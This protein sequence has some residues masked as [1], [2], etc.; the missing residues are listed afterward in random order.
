MSC[1]RCLSCH[2]LASICS[3]VRCWQAWPQPTR[4]WE[5]WTS[6]AAATQRAWSCA[7]TRQQTVRTSGCNH[8]VQHDRHLH[9]AVAGAHLSHAQANSRLQTAYLTASLGTSMQQKFRLLTAQGLCKC[10]DTDTTCL[11][12]CCCRRCLAEWSIYFHLHLAES[13]AAKGQAEEAS[14]QVEQAAA[15]AGSQG[16]LQQQVRGHGLRTC[17]TCLQNWQQ[18]YALALIE[19]RHQPPL[20]LRCNVHHV[21]WFP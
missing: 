18:P 11:L 1:R 20:T 19:G 21:L 10:K 5:R 2:C 15:L 4:R 16:L 7:R 17:H 14:K 8:P 12:C 9:P 13:M 3:S 6:S